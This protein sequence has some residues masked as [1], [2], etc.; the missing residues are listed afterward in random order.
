ML[1]VNDAGKFYV[2][3]KEFPAFPEIE[4]QIVMIKEVSDEGIRLNFTDDCRPV[5][6]TYQL[7]PAANDNGWYDVT[8]LIMLAN[9]TILPKYSA[10]AFIN[11]VA[12]NYRNFIDVNVRPI[13]EQS[14][15]G[16]LCLLGNVNGKT[17]TFT[18]QAYYVVSSDENG[19]IL[20]YS[21]F[22]QPLESWEKPKIQQRVL[23]L[24]GTTRKLF[25]AKTI[26]DACNA[27]YY[28]DFKLANKYTTEISDAA[29][30]SSA[31]TGVSKEVF[32]SGVAKMNVV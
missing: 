18:K 20:A 31:E 3:I 22:C 1:N 2:R 26:V 29:C 19:Y 27:A 13:D 28:E 7:P 11:D 30:A 16:M 14:A 9:S 8:Q 17:L 5:G 10:C 21:G 6:N 25:P 32:T 24:T 23:R 15:A 4:G 12:M